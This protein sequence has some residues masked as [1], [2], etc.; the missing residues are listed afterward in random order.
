MVCARA[1]Y[2]GS[3]LLGVIA[4]EIPVNPVSG[5]VTA[6]RSGYLSFLTSSDGR[7]LSGDK[8][9]A[10]LSGSAEELKHY[11]RSGKKGVFQLKG[12]DGPLL[13]ACA[14]VP[15]CGW[16]LVICQPE[17][18]ALKSIADMEKRLK[19]DRETA[20]AQFEGR[21]SQM[22]PGYILI[23]ASL[24]IL[25][26]LLG[27]LLARQLTRPISTLMESAHAI[28]SGHLTTRS[29]CIPAM[30]SNSWPIR[31]TRWRTT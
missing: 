30:N 1:A 18:L 22:T 31:S 10:A 15:E 6:I 21:I 16:K 3:R 9:F 26:L 8:E 11:I 4:A 29:I 5:Q 28:G 19:T 7:I 13:A 2:S 24:L 25:L 17:S 14:P 27:Y 12:E 20:Q 23:I